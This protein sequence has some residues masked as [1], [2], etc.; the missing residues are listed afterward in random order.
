[1]FPASPHG[2]AAR[3][4]G[5]TRLGSCLAGSHPRGGRLW[6]GERPGMLAQK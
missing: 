5:L 3:A 1:M 6:G 2:T 4:P